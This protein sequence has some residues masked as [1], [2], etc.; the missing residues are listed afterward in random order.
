MF[1][2]A[3]MLKSFLD[4]SVEVV[5]MASLV[6]GLSALGV[7]LGIALALWIGPTVAAFV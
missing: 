2:V 4:E 7:G 6:G 5:W 1:G 3:K